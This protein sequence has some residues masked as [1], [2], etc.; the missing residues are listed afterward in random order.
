MVNGRPQGPANSA[1]LPGRAGDVVCTASG[2]ANSPPRGPVQ[3]RCLEAA[4]EREHCRWDKR[5]LSFGLTLDNT[6]MLSGTCGDA[7]S[8]E[9]VRTAAEAF[10]PPGG[11]ADNAGRP[12]HPESSGMPPAQITPG[13]RGRTH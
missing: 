2:Y 11:Q 3:D 5:H 8:Y 1:Q 6:G 12:G 4:E 7:V 9:I 10:S 13:C